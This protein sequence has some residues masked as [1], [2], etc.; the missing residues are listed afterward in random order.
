MKSHDEF[1]ELLGAY[2]LD[3]VDPDERD[4]VAAHLVTCARCRAEVAEHREVAALLANTGAVA[5]D[6]LWDRISG[7]LDAAPPPIDLGAIRQRRRW[8]PSQAVLGAV[9]AAAVVVVALLGWQVNDQGRR[10]DDLQAAVADPMAPAFEAALDDPRSQVFEL[11][12]TDGDLKVRGA[13]APDGTGYLRAS[14]LPG[15]DAGRTY[16]LWGITGDRAV[17]LGILGNE[18]GVVSFSW[19]DYT[20]I[21]VTDE[22]AP[23]V[24][25]S[26][27]KPVV[28]GEL[29]EPA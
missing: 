22:V 1:A 19:L 25:E 15:L 16:Q 14:A 23:G 18:P 3:A 8:L 5:P 12:S 17:S 20:V 29:S 7:S 13:I 11:A 21:A 24:V 26:Q 10:I 27:N 28:A 2:A 6:G 4:E 9:A